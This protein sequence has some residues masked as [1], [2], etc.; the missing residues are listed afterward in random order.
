MEITKNQAAFA[1]VSITAIA[2]I[3]AVAGAV[4][5]T[6][7]ATKVAYIGLSVLLGTTNLAAITSYF[8]VDD[9][10]DASAYFDKFKDHLQT[11]IPA[12]LSAV[13]QTLLQAVIQGIAEGIRDAIRR[14]ISGPD[15]VIENRKKTI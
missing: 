8:A 3:G 9:F 13:S 4:T 1:T 14:A 5:A 10:K 11:G 15:V 12:V 6:T 7:L 2:T